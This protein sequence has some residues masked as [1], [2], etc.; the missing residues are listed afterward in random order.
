MLISYDGTD[1]CGWQ[2]QGK[3]EHASQLP[4]VQETMELALAKIFNHSVDVSASGRTDA[5]VHAAGQVIHFETERPIPKDI[6]WALKG[7]LP[8]S[9]SAKAAWEAPKEFHSTLS[10][11]HKTYRYWVWNDPRSTALLSRYTT[12]IRKPLDL[13]FLNECSKFLIKKQDFASFRSMGTPVKHT[14][15]EVYGA[16]WHWLKP[17]LLE[18]RI[19]GNGFLKQMVRNIVGTQLDLCLKGQSSERMIEIL[20]AKDRTKA[21]PAAPPQGLF[22]YRVY[23][24]KSLDN[25]C[26]QI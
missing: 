3:H 9:I 19:T 25:K 12:W 5:G 23:Y 22:L 11:T 14:T 26:R 6:C 4:S 16:E 20:E 18:F 13:K 7:K 21:G 15:R 17:R 10:A 24:P 8:D 1:F 2:R